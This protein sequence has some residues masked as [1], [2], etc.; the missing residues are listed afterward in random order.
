MGQPAVVFKVNGTT[1]Q[2]RAPASYPGETGISP[3]QFWTQFWAERLQALERH[4][5]STQTSSSDP[6]PSGAGPDARRRP[7]VLISQL[8]KCSQGR[9]APATVRSDRWLNM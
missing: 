5:K 4:L 7:L 9:Q 3:E 2:S 8:G 6:G 1:R